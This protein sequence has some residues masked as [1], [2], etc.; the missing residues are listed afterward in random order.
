MPSS[1]RCSRRPAAALMIAMLSLGG[2]GKGGSDG[3]ANEICPPVVGYSAVDQ[4]RAIDELA[5]MLEDTAIVE[6]LSD[7]AVMREQSRAC[8][9]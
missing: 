4:A 7:Y 5:L 3:R 1:A 8:M 9:G 6:M 2:C